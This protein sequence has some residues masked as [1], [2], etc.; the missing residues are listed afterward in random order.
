M[1]KMLLFGTT[2]AMTCSLPQF[3]IQ[4]IV[5]AECHP[6][7]AERPGH[8]RRQGTLFMEDHDTRITTPVKQ[9]QEELDCTNPFCFSLKV[10][11]RL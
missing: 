10:L 7:S 3:I 6:A 5:H 8:C 11:I 9:V 1:E 4:T 2:T